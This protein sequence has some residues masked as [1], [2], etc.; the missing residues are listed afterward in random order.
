M[1]NNNIG[2]VG[3]EEL[4]KVIHKE[5][6]W[7]LELISYLFPIH[8]GKTKLE[9]VLIFGS[10]VRGKRKPHDID[11]IP[12][13][14][15]TYKKGDFD[16]IHEEAYT[17]CELLQFRAN[18]SRK[19]YI[20]IMEESSVGNPLYINCNTPRS[21]RDDLS[22]IELLFDD[23]R[24]TNHPFRIA[25]SYIIGSEYIEKLAKESFKK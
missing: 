7:P 8:V 1:K 9:G 17:L 2:G 10:L 5:Y 18:I 20:S 16:I 13:I 12:L 22:R 15:T 6:H 4:K 11:M 14:S 21:F 3:Y 25:S 23:T 24:S 19:P